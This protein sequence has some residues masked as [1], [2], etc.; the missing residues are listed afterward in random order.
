MRAHQYLLLH[1]AVVERQGKA[2][3]FPAWPG[4][5]KS[6]LSAALSLRGWRLITDEFGMLKPGINEM[7]PLPRCIPLKNESIDVIRQFAPEAVM[8]PVFG[9]TR[10]GDVAHLSPGA[11]SVRRMQ[12][13]A[14]PAYVVFPRFVKEAPVKVQT[15]ALSQGVNHV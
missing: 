10:K 2:V 6:T 14:V 5:G 3:L 13:T 11:D 8:G 4:S 1:S 15:E 7:V 12:E 9:K